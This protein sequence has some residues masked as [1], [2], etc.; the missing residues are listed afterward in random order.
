MDGWEYAQELSSSFVGKAHQAHI[1]R[2]LWVREVI[3]SNNYDES[4]A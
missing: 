3:T 4:L 1:R 2:R